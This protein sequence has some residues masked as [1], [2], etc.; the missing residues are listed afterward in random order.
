MGN[1]EK[2]LRQPAINLEFPVTGSIQTQREFS[3]CHLPEDRVACRW[4]PLT[5]CYLLFLLD[6]LLYTVSHYFLRTM[7][8][9]GCAS[10]DD[11]DYVPSD[12]EAPD[13]DDG[14]EGIDEGMEELHDGQHMKRPPQFG[15]NRYD[16][17]NFVA[18]SRLFACL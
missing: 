9:E 1:S 15:D 17:V 16:F 13:D 12:P 2:A 14:D 18:H 11:E 3:L 10:S 6:A 7:S 8:H 4:V 5:V